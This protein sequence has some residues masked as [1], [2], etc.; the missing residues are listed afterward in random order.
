[1]P[2]SEWDDSWA[3][4]RYEPPSLRSEGFIHAS[5]LSQVLATAERYFAGRHDI[6]LLCIDPSLLQCEVFYEDLKGTGVT[7]P[8]IYGSVTYAAV[9]AA[10][11]LPVDAEG[12]FKLPRTFLQ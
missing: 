7:Y 9:I 5:T 12:H 3:W 4:G 1:M 6:V 11:D 8:H 2:R 10:Y